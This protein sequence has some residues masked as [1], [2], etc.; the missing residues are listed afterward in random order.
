MKRFAQV[1]SADAVSKALVG[2]AAVALI[3]YMPTGEYAAL[4]F[5][6][7]VA[8]M[9]GQVLAAGFNRIYI[10]GFE[11]LRLEERMAPFVAAQVWLL[12]ALVL[13][14]A[15]LVR[16]LDVS[17]P[18]VVAVAVGL[19]LSEFA[20]TF[21][22]RRLAFGRYS[23]IEF[24]RALAQAAGIAALIAIFGS[25][26]RA[27]PVLAV[28]GA[29]LLAPFALTLG[30]RLNWTRML[31]VAAARELLRDV[32][33][34]PYPRLL[35]YF[36]LVAV[37]SQVDILMLKALADEQQLASYGS[38]FRY[39]SLLMLALGA[40]HTVL[41]PAIQQSGSGAALDRLYRQHFRLL[42]LFTPTVLLVAWLSAWVLPWIDQGRYPEAV[43]VFR[44]LCASAVISFACSPHVNLLMKLQHFAFLLYLVLGALAAAFVLHLVLI[45]RAG[46]LGAAWA[47][48][49]GSAFVTV[50][51]FFLARRL[52][53]GLDERRAT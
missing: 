52:R 41:L 35:V 39:Y 14:A 5:A 49:A 3:R 17:Y 7:T 32:L 26:L 16:V 12:L 36:A 20:K 47:T 53:A 30:L 44:I 18:L 46:A 27:E 21:Y 4:T 43:P 10:L 22:Q 48:L 31:D 23:A 1:L 8:T 34:S 37:F 33:K 6:L 42:A 24:A 9:G 38:A 28:Q 2:I 15:P 13:A 29:A 45:P 25:G 11:S 40:A 50:P 19:L 51:I